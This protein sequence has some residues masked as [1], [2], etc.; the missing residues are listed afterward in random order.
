MLRQNNIKY[1]FLYHLKF[2]EIILY[3]YNYFCLIFRTKKQIELVIVRCK[4]SN[5]TPGERKLKK[6]AIQEQVQ[7]SSSASKKININVDALVLSDIEP[8]S[9]NET[10]ENDLDYNEKAIG[11]KQNSKE[12]WEEK[13]MY[14]GREGETAYPN[15]GNW[16]AHRGG[17][18][19]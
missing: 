8:I 19:E 7:A 6:R 9:D 1:L 4:N 14:R 17:G 13:E 18:I 10:E 15:Q 16:R 3:V 2:K 12:K 11:Y 5:Q